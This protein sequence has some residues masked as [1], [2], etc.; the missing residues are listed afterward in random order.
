MSAVLFR[1]DASAVIGLGHVMR[2]VALGQELRRAGASVVFAAHALP[3]ATRAR[4]EAEGFAVRAVGSSPGSRDDAEETLALARAM[5]ARWVVVDG[6]TFGADHQRV[7]GRAGVR[8]AWLDDLADLERYDVDL[9]LNQNL[10]ASAARYAGRV[11][12]GCRLLL[13]PRYALLREEVRRGRARRRHGGASTDRLL[14][15]FGGGDP[16]DLTSRALEALHDDRLRALQA[17]VVVGAANSRR[18]EL[19]RLALALGERVE[20]LVD[21]PDMAA[22]L[23]AADLCLSAAGSVIWELAYFGVPCA[24]V[25]VAENQRQN[26][27]RA[28]VD[29]LALL[30]GG[31]RGLEPRDL[32]DAI[33]ALHSDPALRRSLAAVGPGLVDGEGAARVAQVMSSG[34]DV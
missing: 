6:Y 32:A 15:M 16:D 4:L 13:G 19:E 14:V 22:V 23:G 21:V 17:T 1:A 25:I 31:A 33:H 26:A 11:P 24:L 12:Q 29:G 20:V 3:P 7:L 2:C 8:V 18:R 27:L 34:E 9:L 30:L 28:A 10:D 5:G